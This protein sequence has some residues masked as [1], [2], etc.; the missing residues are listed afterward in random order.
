MKFK[1]YLRKIEI[2]SMKMF[3][4]DKSITK[5]VAKF[6]RDEISNKK[7]RIMCTEENILSIDYELYGK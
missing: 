6:P 1:K 7:Y 4:S 3:Y 2:Q 5:T